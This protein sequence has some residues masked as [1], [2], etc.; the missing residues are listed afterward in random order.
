MGGV[1][2]TVAKV[3]GVKPPKPKAA[4]VVQKVAKTSAA[5]AKKTVSAAA[6]KAGAALGSYGGS[7]MMTGA[8]GVVEEANVA[9]TV[10]GG[11]VDKAKKKMKSAVS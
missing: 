10:L 2:R 5:T 7:T 11:A 8:G 1:V 4:A 6:D 3:F 9:K